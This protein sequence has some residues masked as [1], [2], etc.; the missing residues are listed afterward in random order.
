MLMRARLCFLLLAASSLASCGRDDEMVRLAGVPY[1]LPSEDVGAIVA[2]S[3]TPDGSYYVRLIPADA[4][5]RLVYSPLKAGRPNLQGENT[6]TIPHIND[7]PSAKIDVF[8]SEIGPI[9]CRANSTLRF[10]C[11][12]RIVDAGVSWGVNFDRDQLANASRIKE[13]AQSKLQSY[14]TDRRL[15]KI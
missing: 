8:R 15:R 14:R 11:G 9:V 7:V 4:G 3:E 6:P 13:Q 12:F 2:P 1:Y 10:S 5:Y